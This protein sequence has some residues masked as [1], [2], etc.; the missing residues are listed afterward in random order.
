MDYTVPNDF[1]IKTY[2]LT[3]NEY[4]NKYQIKY[5]D[6]ESYLRDGGEEG[7]AKI[8]HYMSTKYTH[9]ELRNM[10]RSRDGS[11]A[12][13]IRYLEEL[14]DRYDIEI[15]QEFVIEMSHMKWK[16]YQLKYS[17]NK[18]NVT[19]LRN[20]YSRRITSKKQLYIRYLQSLLSN[21]HQNDSNRPDIDIVDHRPP[22]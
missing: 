13:Y 5:F 14:L 3:F 18:I 10:H 1:I 21:N 17:N 11:I 6:K 9:Q 16:E 15:P 22:Y 4:Y 12:R 19:Q 2:K 8:N 20:V 7:G